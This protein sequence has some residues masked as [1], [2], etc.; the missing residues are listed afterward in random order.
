MTTTFFL[1]NEININKK[2]KHT[3][4]REVYPNQANKT[5]P[6]LLKQTTIYRV[7]NETPHLKSNTREALEMGL[8]APTA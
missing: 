2:K 6:W 7:Q 4:L 5:L 8:Y 1:P 3:C